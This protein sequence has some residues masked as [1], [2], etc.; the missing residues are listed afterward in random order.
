MN[1]DGGPSGAVDTSAELARQINQWKVIYSSENVTLKE[2]IETLKAKYQSEV[3]NH[4]KTTAFLGDE[5]AAKRDLERDIA[6]LK[7]LNTATIQNSKERIQEF[8]DDKG[9]Y[10]SRVLGASHAS[11]SLRNSVENHHLE[12]R[13]F[14]PTDTG[15]D[16]GRCR[17]SGSAQSPTR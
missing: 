7:E 9:Q 14:T 4:T 13:V 16:Q 12:S 6:H 2:Q 10:M 8:K 17:A 5:K 1:K 3:E 15:K 11:Q